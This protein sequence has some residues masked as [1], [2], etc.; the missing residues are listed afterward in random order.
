MN[1]LGQGAL[2]LGVSYALAVGYL[3][4][5]RLLGGILTK[6]YPEEH[7]VYG[8]RAQSP[9]HNTGCSLRCGAM[10]KI[11]DATIALDA[12]A[13]YFAASYFGWLSL[14]QLPP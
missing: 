9:R 11:P 14:L 4:L 1:A 2:G 10:I 8:T 7:K 13:G 12:A 3:L 5:M 6:Q